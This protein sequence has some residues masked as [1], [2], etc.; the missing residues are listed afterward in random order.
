M[1]ESENVRYVW[2]HLDQP[3]TPG[4]SAMLIASHYPND[5]TL[6]TLRVYDLNFRGSL[7]LTVVDGA[8][9]QPSAEACRAVAQAR[10]LE[11]VREETLG[12]S[13][14]SD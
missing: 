13:G 5:V 4:K 1:S 11:I 10:G 12:Q 8:F 7:V 2:P 14:S 3:I 6:Y 9:Q